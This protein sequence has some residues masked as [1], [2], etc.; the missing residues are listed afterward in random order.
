MKKDK[1][2]KGFFDSIKSFSDDVIETA[3]K[4]KDEIIEDAKEMPSRVVSATR[5]M[6]DTIKKAIDEEL[7]IS[8]KD[9]GINRFRKKMMY[10]GT[11]VGDA[12][13][14]TIDDVK[15][16]KTEHK[17]IGD[18]ISNVAEHLGQNL[19]R[20]V[21]DET[22]FEDLPVTSDIHEAGKDK[23]HIQGIGK[24]L[25]LSEQAFRERHQKLE[26]ELEELRKINEELRSLLEEAL[27]KT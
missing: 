15:A 10:R 7:T 5:E 4:K 25:E 2:G 13:I 23:G 1:K 11:P 9:K 22:V 24:G 18:K 6:P 14:K 17:T 27:K 21:I 16:D 3:K 26:E 12:V 8:E 19:K 20:S